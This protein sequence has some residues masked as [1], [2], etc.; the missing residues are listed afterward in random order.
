MGV[1]ELVPEL[2]LAYGIPK[3]VKGLIIAESANQAEAAGLLAGDVIQRINKRRVRTIV[4]FMKVMRKADLNKGVY[5]DVY[6]QGQ[7]FQLKMK[8]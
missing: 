8:N 3:G 1:E 7:T 5:L 6:R 2:A 4:D